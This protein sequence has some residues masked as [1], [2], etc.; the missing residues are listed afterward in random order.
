[1]ALGAGLAALAMTTRSAG[2]AVSSLLSR[3]G[4]SVV[5]SLGAAAGTAPSCDAE[6]AAAVADAD[7]AGGR[8]WTAAAA[9]LAAGRA[10]LTTAT[11]ALERR[12][13][14]VAVAE[15]AA[16]AAKADADAAAATAAAAEAAAT[17]AKADADAAAAAAAAAEVPDAPTPVCRSA[18]PGSRAGSFLIVFMGH[19]GS[20]ALLSELGQH[21]GTHVALPE[22]VDH[23]PYRRNTSAALA[24][25]R[26]FFTAGQKKGLMPG[27]KIRPYHIEQD[28]DAWRAL[29]EEFDTRLIWNFRVNIL[30]ASVGEYTARYLNDTSVIEGIIPGSEAD[31]CK[32]GAGCQFAVTNMDFLHTMM[33][34]FVSSDRRIAGAVEALQEAG[35]D[36]PR[37]CVL[38]APYEEYLLSRRSVMKQVHAFL[39]LGD[40]DHMP[41]RAKAT[42]D[43][44][45]EAV[46]N[47]ED[48]CNAFYGCVEW[49][50]MMDD[51]RNG[52]KCS[53][54]E[55]GGYSHM[56]TKYCSMN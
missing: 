14:D 55:T 17:K 31:R 11:G 19:S 49:R 48:V 53:G 4:A 2:R 16:A 32:T 47:W 21:S 40:E 12:E 6:V 24:Y 51:V 3:T 23:E 20:T 1:V 39:G 44:M 37:R 35:A 36:R 45:C 34:M 41:N 56:R 26:A 15:A 9:A 13:A 22:P 5:A 8:N 18:K 43:S 54:V 7:A 42:N 33:R 10:E 46:T 29:V 50:W 38:T 27:F 30:K 25:T 28:P 52:C